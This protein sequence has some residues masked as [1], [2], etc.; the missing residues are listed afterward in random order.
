MYV[1][2]TASGE[3]AEASRRETIAAL[4]GHGRSPSVGATHTLSGDQ[5]RKKPTSPGTPPGKLMIIAFSL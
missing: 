3:R 5:S 2:H 4:A 1:T